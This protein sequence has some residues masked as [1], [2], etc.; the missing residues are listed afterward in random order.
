MVV[1]LIEEDL[2]FNLVDRKG[3]DYLFRSGVGVIALLV[4]GDLAVARANEG[5][6][7]N[8]GDGTNVR[9]IGGKGDR[10]TAVAD[11]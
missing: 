1:G 11:C 3:V 8:V 9:T 2:L 7:V 10:Q 4:C 5:N 6:L